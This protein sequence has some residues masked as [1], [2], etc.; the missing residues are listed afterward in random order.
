MLQ[1]YVNATV[2]KVI[3]QKNF[4]IIL[5]GV[6]AFT[7]VLLAFGMLSKSERVILVPPEINKSFW[8]TRTKVSDEYLQE[9]AVFLADLI[10]DQTPESA[11][12]KRD[13]LMKYV[14]AGYHNALFEKLIKQEDYITQNDVSTEFVL[15]EAVPVN[16]AVEITGEVITYVASKQLSRALVKYTAEFE[17]KGKL[18]LSKFEQ[19]AT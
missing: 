1:D 3:Q 6:L 10:L 19:V 8:V 5:T 14:S 13:M 18:L 11:K 4:L 17:Y 7:N 2:K 16:G 12:V 9:M 15:K